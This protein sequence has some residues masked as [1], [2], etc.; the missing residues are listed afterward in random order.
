MG[1]F[2]R[3]VEERFAAVR[4]D[5]DQRIVNVDRPVVAGA[6]G[7]RCAT[8]GIVSI[9]GG[10][11]A[12]ALYG[13]MMGSAIV[14]GVRGEAGDAEDRAAVEG[15]IILASMFCNLVGLVAGIAGLARRNQKK[16]PAIIG[17]AVNLALVLA[18]AG[19]VVLA[20]M[21]GLG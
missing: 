10:L 16:G 3:V 12:G 20:K 13:A 9:A 17:L 11:V 1:R 21:R 15:A 19:L 2:R 8:L 14:A 5:A 18:V 6:L 7:A 4:A